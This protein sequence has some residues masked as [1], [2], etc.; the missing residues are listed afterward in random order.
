[1]PVPPPALVS[2]PP[3]WA[4]PPPSKRMQADDCR[5]LARGLLPVPTVFLHRFGQS[6]SRLRKRA[7]TISRL[8]AWTAGRLRHPSK[9]MSGRQSYILRETTGVAD[10]PRRKSARCSRLW[11]V[12]SPISDHAVALGA[13]GCGHR[14]YFQAR[15]LGVT[16]APQSSEDCH[17]RCLE[18]SWRRC[19]SEAAAARR[20]MGKSN[21]C[22]TTGCCGQRQL[23][24]VMRHPSKL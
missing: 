8:P 2:S 9:S 7:A 13:T 4:D 6:I 15:T 18:A 10:A 16:E 22:P 3:A 5:Q 21:L 23:E 11:L 20:V 14:R 19:R 24:C 1:M 12:L 17:S